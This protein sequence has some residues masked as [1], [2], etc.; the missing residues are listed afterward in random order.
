MKGIPEALM[1]IHGPL[2]QAIF[3]L[4]NMFALAA[5][6]EQDFWSQKSEVRELSPLPIPELTVHCYLN[7]FRFLG[8]QNEL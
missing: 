3:A 6:K 8:L 7:T 2:A 1:L 5:K 4:E